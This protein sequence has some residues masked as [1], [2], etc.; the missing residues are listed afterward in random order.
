MT[1]MSGATATAPRAD[2]ARVAASSAGRAAGYCW[3]QH[4]DQALFCTRPA[5]HTGEHR[6]YYA[7]V[8]WH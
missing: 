2:R 6:H 5:G 3:I 1:T 7:R 8:D 4:P